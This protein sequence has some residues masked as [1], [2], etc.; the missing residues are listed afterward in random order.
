[1]YT[2][3]ER[4]RLI[5]LAHQNYRRSQ[6]RFRFLYYVILI[7]GLVCTTLGSYWCLIRLNMQLTQAL[8]Y[9][10]PLVVLPTQTLYQLQLRLDLLS[11]IL[12][13]LENG[14]CFIEANT[15]PRTNL[16]VLFLCVQDPKRPHITLDIAQYIRTA[17]K[18]AQGKEF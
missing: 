14:H 16:Q 6:K 4:D 3:E 13:S 12:V 1:M 5:E 17:P 8:L 18:S 2:P 7:F 15:E 10:L 11:H 9:L